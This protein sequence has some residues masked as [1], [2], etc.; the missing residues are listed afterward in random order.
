MICHTGA[1]FEEGE[2]LHSRTHTYAEIQL[3]FAHR[4]VE[5]PREQRTCLD[6][7]E[8]DSTVFCGV[9]GIELL[10]YLFIIVLVKD[11]HVFR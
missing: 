9:F 6:H 10:L 1:V 7:F 11:I 4:C 3:C 8:T 5:V 2:I